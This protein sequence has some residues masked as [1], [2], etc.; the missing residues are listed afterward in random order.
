MNT[1]IRTRTPLGMLAALG[2]A[3]ALAGCGSDTASDATTVTV[4]GDVP[5]AYVKRANTMRM[6][7]TNGAPSAPGGDL[8]IREKSSP[9]APEHN[10]T[11][12]FTQNVGDASDPEVSYDGKKII[13]SMRCPTT[14]TST[15]DGQP[16]CT[17]RWN[18]WEYD[19][20][21]T[22][23]TEGKF[24]RLTATTDDDDVDPAYLPAGRGFVFSSNRQTTSKVNQS[25]G[26]TYFALDEY[27]RERVFNLH[28]MDATG[29]EIGRAHV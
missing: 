6:N 5:I 12:R 29:Q 23:F 1:F 16:A 15:I 26:Q 10:V 20:T 27:E 25:L 4:S 19:M 17:G 13:F 2:I 9:S 18:I 22:G 21:G 11:A 28:T 7:P 3:A 14:N 8:L 24:R